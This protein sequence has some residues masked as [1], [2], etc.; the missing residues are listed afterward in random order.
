MYA[1]TTI[2]TDLR[3]KI[4]LK[5]SLIS[6]FKHNRREVEKGKMQGTTKWG[7]QIDQQ[8]RRLKITSYVT[9][10]SEAESCWTQDRR[11]FAS[12]FSPFS[13]TQKCLIIKVFQP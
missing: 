2:T 6:E 10:L 3:V 12:P 11:T 9:F 5:A 1:T 7:N 8:I 4:S 13:Q